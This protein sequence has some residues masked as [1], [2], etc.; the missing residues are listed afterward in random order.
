MLLQD[1][2]GHRLELVRVRGYSPVW[3]E[4]EGLELRCVDDGS[5]ITEWALE[6]PDEDYSL[7]EDDDERE[8]IVFVK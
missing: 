5:L 4:G 7:D 2:V 3:G 8:P 1:H 6:E